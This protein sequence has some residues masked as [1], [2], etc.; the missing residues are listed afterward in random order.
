MSQRAKAG[1]NP[2]RFPVPEL[3]DVVL[4]PTTVSDNWLRRW[5]IC[6]EPL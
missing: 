2:P 5:P 3:D 6:D 4:I 1:F